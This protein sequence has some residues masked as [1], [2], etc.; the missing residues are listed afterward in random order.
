VAA[1]DR[2]AI[3]AA[4]D[5]AETTAKRVQLGPGVYIGTRPSRTARASICDLFY[6]DALFVRLANG[7]TRSE[8]REPRL[9][10]ERT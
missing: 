5:E 3:Q 10:H 7:T 1:T 2:A 4:I 6:T 9:A 8:D